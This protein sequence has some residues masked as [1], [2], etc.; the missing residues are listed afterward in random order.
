MCWARGGVYGTKLIADTGSVLDVPGRTRSLAFEVPIDP[1]STLSGLRRGSGDPTFRIAPDGAIWR[2]VRTPAGPATV[3]ITARPRERTV[4]A[5][6][7]G[8]GAEWMLEQLPG[9]VGGEDDPSGFEPGL[10]LLERARQRYAGWR[11]CRTGLVMEALIPAILEQKVTA[12]EA[13]RSWRELTWRYGE[14]AP[15]QDLPVKLWV[16]PEPA[17]L[18]ALPV[19]DWHQAGVGPDRRRTLIRACTVAGRLEETISFAPAEAERRLRSIPGIGVWTA[20]EVRQRAHGDPDAVSVGDFN[21]PKLI[22]HALAGE[23]WDDEAMLAALER[24]RG[25][26]YRVTRLLEMAAFGGMVSPPPRRGPRFAP[27]DYRSM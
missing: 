24:W 20:A 26:R 12:T 10:P 21:L 13:W 11:V 16:M 4:T 1:A 27:R 6:A 9:M 8:T 18:A 7:W 22:G 19:W 14:R 5:Q 2:G 3:R 23:R 15:G 25:H 17:T